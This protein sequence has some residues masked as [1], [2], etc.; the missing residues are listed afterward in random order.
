[1]IKESLGKESATLEGSLIKIKALESQQALSQEEIASN[2]KVIEDQKVKVQKLMDDINASNVS[3]EKKTKDLAS[4]RKAI[5]EA[6]DYILE[7]HF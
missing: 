1:M 5:Y 6:D 4:A 7:T 2:R 3:L